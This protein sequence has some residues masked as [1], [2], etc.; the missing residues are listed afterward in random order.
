MANPEE[1]TLVLEDKVD[2]RDRIPGKQKL[3]FKRHREP[4]K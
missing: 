2:P 4:N 3:L 1:F